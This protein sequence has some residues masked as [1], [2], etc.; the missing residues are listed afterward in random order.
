MAT[1]LSRPSRERR[2]T[3]DDASTA[4]AAHVATL[5]GRHPIEA[6]QA[7]AADTADPGRAALLRAATRAQR[8]ASVP[9]GDGLPLPH[10]LDC[11]WRFAE[12]TAEALLAEAVG[13]TGPGDAILLLGVPSLA[14]VARSSTSDRLFHVVGEDNA[15]S[16]ALRCGTAGDVRFDHGTPSSRS[17]GAVVLDPPWYP[18]PFASMLARA[19]AA[20]RAGAYVVS[21]L[22]PIGLRPGVEIDRAVIL[23]H[24]AR[25]GLN[26]IRHEQDA[27]V[28]RSPVFELSA[29]RAAGI[30]AWLPEW[31]RGDVVRFEAGDSPEP[32]EVTMS[33]E[34]AFELTS[35]GVRLRLLARDADSGQVTSPSIVGN[36]FPSVSSRAPGRGK[37]NLWTTTNRAFRVAPRPA[38]VALLALARA[39]GVR[40]QGLGPEP[41]ALQTLS[42][43][44]GDPSLTHQ[45]NALVDRE[46]DDAAVLAGEASWER[47][48]EDARFLHG[49]STSFLAA[50]VGAGR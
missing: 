10:P 34:P 12:R 27:V 3:S 38:L 24:A 20:C 30:G 19:A 45:L 14:V 13:R 22:P 39:R 2:Q 36:V 35:R 25:L 48:V 5:A 37:S 4:F 6:F 26:L 47:S 50:L 41:N 8:P 7:L 28:Y 32:E 1:R 15:V 46:V 40:P 49:S 44:D 43:I 31:R 16:E 21:T 42:A 23:A 29:M 17:V 18:R 9:Q 33:G 11:E